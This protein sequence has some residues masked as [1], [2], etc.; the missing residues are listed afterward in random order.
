MIIYEFLKFQKKLKINNI[1]IVWENEYRQNKKET[2][3][4]IINIIKNQVLKNNEE[5]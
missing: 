3:D 5:N 4:K 1:I 2:K